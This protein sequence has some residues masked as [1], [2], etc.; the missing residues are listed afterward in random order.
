MSTINLIIRPLLPLSPSQKGFVGCDGCVEHTFTLQEVLDN[1]RRFRKNACITWIDITKAFDSV[2]HPEIFNMLATNLFP[3]SLTNFITNLYSKSYNVAHD[4]QGN[5]SKIPMNGRGVRQGCPL[6]PLMFNLIIDPLLEKLNNSDGG[7]NLRGTSI[8][9][10]AF[11]D[12]IVLISNTQEEMS[13]LLKV[14]ES[15]LNNLQMKINIDKCSKVTITYKNSKRHINDPAQDVSNPLMVNNIQIPNLSNF[16]KYLG[17]TSDLATFKNLP[18]AFDEFLHKLNKLTLSPLL[19]FM[20]LQLYKIYLQ[21][22]LE[23]VTKT[24]C[25]RVE[26]L[27]KV[28]SKI[29]ESL[30]KWFN[31]PHTSS[32][33]FIYTPVPLGGLGIRNIRQDYAALRLAAGLNLIHSLD[34]KISGVAR[35]S[36]IQTTTL[37]TK[38]QLTPLNYLNS[39][40]EVTKVHDIRTLMSSLRIHRKALGIPLINQAGINDLMHIDLDRSCMLNP[41]NISPQSMSRNQHPTRIKLLRWHIQESYFREWKRQPDQGRLVDCFS[42]FPT[43]NNWIKSGNL[44]VST[45]RFGL[46]GRLNILPTK[47][48]LHRTKLSPDAICRHC[49]CSVETLG[50]VLGGCKRGEALRTLRHNHVVHLITDQI[51]KKLAQKKNQ[52]TQYWEVIEDKQLPHGI[53]NRR[54]DITL[55]NWKKKLV[56]I[57]DVA[58]S[59][60]NGMDRLDQ[61]LQHKSEKYAPEGR[62]LEQL[63]YGVLR[64]ALVFGS[65][66]SHHPSSM[67]TLDRFCLMKNKKIQKRLLK[68]IT[69]SVLEDSRLVWNNH[70]QSVVIPR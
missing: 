48:I 22:T 23:F 57:I 5:S 3:P 66:G 56:Q 47:S 64:S 9:V 33:S 10:Q 1:S 19:P 52:A 45:Y 37:R 58:I 49:P 12:D 15:F 17:T 41:S 13:K 40:F 30:R 28:D 50:H 54:P 8:K 11:A 38:D 46:M 62:A 20:K 26:Q 25:L 36:L 63:G 59:Y 21:P 65:L 7:F 43:A 32:R 68:D 51:K 60:E 29:L 70:V 4:N 44:R 6:S 42:W 67:G 16:Y 35:E 61:V 55:W 18:P 27:K 2:P 53:S 14:T 69:H 39:E 24:H 34:D 31:F